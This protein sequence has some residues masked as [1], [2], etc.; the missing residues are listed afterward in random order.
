[1]VKHTLRFLLGSATVRDSSI[2]LAGTVI[3]TIC[4][5]FLTI[6]L[7]RGLS[8]AEFGLFITALTFAQLVTDLFELGINSAILNLLPGADLMQRGKILKAAFVLR[9][10]T[11]CVVALAVFFG[12]PILS[13]LIFNSQQIV[14]FVA[15]T[16]LG[17]FLLSIA[18]WMQT[19]FQAQGKFFQSMIINSGINVTRLLIVLALAGLGWLTALNAFFAMQMIVVVAVA[20]GLSHLKVSFLQATLSGAEY[21]KII[22]LGLPVGLSFAIAAVYTKLDQILIFNLVGDKE[23]GIYGLAFRVA[24]AFIFA[25][26]ALGSALVPRFSSLAHIDF[27]DY[28]LKS[29]VAATG[30][31]LLTVCAIPLAP[32]IMPV[33]FGE[34]FV[35]SIQPFQVLTLGTAFF[36]VSSVFT[37]AI[38]YHYKKPAFSLITS[39]ISL[40]SIW[41]LL[42]WLIPLYQSLGAAMAVTSV[43]GIQLVVAAMVFSYYHFRHD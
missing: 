13:Q 26:A 30:L 32:F 11:T 33:I 8:P 21:K 4:G 19:I 34:K 42:Q 38:M 31:A 16:A 22:T 28:F 37:S 17:I 40:V 35:Q 5:F 29:L 25:S 3:A 6:F 43:Y 7:S 41:F 18:S 27:R 14:P 10:V 24:A 9:I 1:M 23:A 20:Y 36:I 15:L 12:A 2:L 39:I